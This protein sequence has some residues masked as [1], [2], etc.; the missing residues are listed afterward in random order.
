MKGVIVM[1]IKEMTE[2][3]YGKDKWLEALNASGQKEEPYLTV[4]SDIDDIFFQKLV[5]SIS[6]AVGRPLSE[7][8]DAFGDFWINTY[9]QRIYKPYYDQCK[10]A[11]EFLLNMDIVHDTVT[12]RIEDAR[13]PQFAYEWKGEKTLL[14]TYKSERGMIDY[15]IGLIKGVGR[16]YQENLQVEKLSEERVK[17]TFP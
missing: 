13:P 14:M 4:S 1:S 9:S 5:K 7:I 17:I 11:A 10:T 3:N 15:M 16:Y 12:R 8:L 2:K 6:T